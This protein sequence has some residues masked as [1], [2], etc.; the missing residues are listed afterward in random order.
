MVFDDFRQNI[1]ILKGKAT[2]AVKKWTQSPQVP[3]KRS[4]MAFLKRGRAAFQER[5]GGA[6][7]EE[8]RARAGRGSDAAGFVAF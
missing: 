3:A 5:P 2:E 1:T 6:A 8:E 7:G 4:T